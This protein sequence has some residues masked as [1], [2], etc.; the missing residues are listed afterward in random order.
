MPGL[1]YFIKQ[2]FADNAIVLLYHRI[3]KPQSDVWNISVTPENF[4]Q[5]LHALQKTKK[6]ID[7]KALI[8]DIANNSIK[9]NSIAITFDDGY[10]NNFYTAK[11]LLEKYELPATFFIA[12][13]NIDKPKE[14]WWDELEHLFLFSERLPSVVSLIINEAEF[15]FN[16]QGEEIL[17]GELIQKHASWKA[18][19][20][21]PPS[22]R[23]EFFLTIWQ[24]LKPLQFE[25]QQTEIEVIK[26]LIGN[27]TSSRPEYKCM[28]SD[29]IK[30]LQSN[31]LFD[32][33]AH[34]VTHP[35][36]PFHNKIYQ[37]KEMAENKFFLEK[38][39]S[40]KVDF[41]AYP[42]GDYND[43]TLIAADE[44][45]FSAAFTTDENIISKKSSIFRL[46][47]YQVKNQSGIEL[48]KNI[49][50]WLKK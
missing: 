17:S 16:F 28:T 27:S 44:T 8:K 25:Q 18:F 3:A 7:L 20:E 42:Y 13:C 24:E 12:S 4:E 30:E 2:I 1:K 31:K 22:L 48:K 26:K 6:V 45:G 15:E 11:P 41:L 33:G 37:K 40:N 49:E 29:Q 35:S 23:C 38:I 46:P 10:A 19:E 47:R 21:T 43:N 34:T 50:K 36:L 32:V 9:K 5:H 14:F 39:I